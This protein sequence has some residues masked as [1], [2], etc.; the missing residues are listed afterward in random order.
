MRNLRA[1]VSQPNNIAFI[2]ESRVALL[3]RAREAE[4]AHSVFVAQGGQ[5]RSVPAC[6][7]LALANSG[8][9][10][11]FHAFDWGCGVETCAQI[12]SSLRRRAFGPGDRFRS[13]P[14][15]TN[16]RPSH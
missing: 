8:G 6:V 4:E 11:G 13:R 10:S 15:I 12:C 14:L 1:L 7:W 9:F 16:A 2:S 5:V 3:W